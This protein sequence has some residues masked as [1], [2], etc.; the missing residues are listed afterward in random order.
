MKLQDS[1][2]N[3]RQ[4]RTAIIDTGGGLRGVYA[5]GVLD[6]LIEKGVQFDLAIGVSAGSANLASFLAGQKG[7]NYIF[8]TQYAQRKEYMGI[9]NFVKN[10]SYVNLDYVYGTLSNSDGEN[11]ID[12]PAIAANPAEFLIVATDA[13]TSEP[14]YFTK[15]DLS[16]DCYD[17]CKAS[18][19]LPFAGPPYPIRGRVY[20][21]GAL[22]DPLPVHIALERG[23][24]R[25]VMLV[26]S[27]RDIPRKSGTDRFFA[28][29]I[30]RK[31]PLSARKMAQRAEL[32][33]SELDRLREYERDGRLL[34]VAPDN[35][36]GVRVLEKRRSRLEV[37]YRKGL[38]DAEIIEEY[39]G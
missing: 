36:C 33:N 8:Y 1:N 29:G 6:H 26:T 16:Q 13:E 19:A 14:V 39:L 27:P 22:S 17:V 35:S 7:R 20:Y 2:K 12:Y 21:D 23:C 18:A 28:R 4:M 9:G 32:V 5:A 3:R 10:G 30:A 37:L 38:S 34:I 15:A 25:I 11:P 31:Y 24:T